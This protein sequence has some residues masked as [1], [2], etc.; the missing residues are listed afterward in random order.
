MDRL[1][2]LAP[3]VT[4]EANDQATEILNLMALAH[5][6]GKDHVLY[7]PSSKTAIHPLVLHTLTSKGYK[8]EPVPPSPTFAFTL[9]G[10]V[11]YKISL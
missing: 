2:Q 3:H 5:Q 8:V 11:P 10:G 4:K 1:Q 6:Q 7:T 9:N